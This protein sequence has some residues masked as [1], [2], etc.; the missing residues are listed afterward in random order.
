MERGGGVAVTAVDPRIPPADEAPLPLSLSEVAEV[1]L[2]VSVAPT[3]LLTE[4][5]ESWLHAQARLGSDAEGGHVNDLRMAL[6]W[7]LQAHSTRAT[8]HTRRAVASVGLALAEALAASTA[9]SEV[10][11]G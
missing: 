9:S 2:G 3:R 4:P 1:L 11:R 6:W 7:A 5:T 8:K 10:T